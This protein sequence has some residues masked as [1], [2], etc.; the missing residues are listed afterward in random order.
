MFKN[1]FSKKDVGFKSK[2]TIEKRKI[3]SDR[4]MEKYPDR[5]PII[6]ERA[7]DSIVEINKTKYLVPNDLTV[8]QFVYVIRNKLK[9]TPE[10][11]IFMFFKNGIMVNCSSTIS[12]CY[13]KYKDEDGFLYIKY[14]GENTFG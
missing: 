12:D 8:G 2:H 11:G 9:L 10:I 4:I 1:I 14:S 5:V 7:N 6:L 13:I 3:E